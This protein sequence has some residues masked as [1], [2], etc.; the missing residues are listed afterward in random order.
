MALPEAT[1]REAELLRQIDD[2]L[3]QVTR[4]HRTRE[5]TNPKLS[6][7]FNKHS[8]Q[9]KQSV[10]HSKQLEQSAEKLSQ[11]EVDNLTLRDENQALNA[12]S[13]KKRRFR[14]RVRPMPTLKHP[15]PGQGATKG[16]YSKQGDSTKARVLEGSSE[17]RDPTMDLGAATCEKLPACWSAPPDRNRCRR[18][19]F[20]GSQCSTRFSGHS[21]MSSHLADTLTCWINKSRTPC[22]LTFDEHPSVG[23][24]TSTSV[25]EME[26]EPLTSEAALSSLGGGMADTGSL[27]MFPRKGDVGNKK[28]E[29]YKEKTEKGRLTP[30]A[31]MTIRA[32]ENKKST[33]YHQPNYCQPPDL[34]L[35]VKPSGL[36]FGNN[37]G[38]RLRRLQD[39]IKSPELLHLRQDIR[40]SR[41]IAPNPGVLSGNRS[42]PGLFPEFDDEIEQQGA[43]V[44][45]KYSGIEF[46]QTPSRTPAARSPLG[47]TPG[48]HYTVFRIRSQ[49]PPPSSGKRKT[50][51]K[52]SLPYF[53]I[54]KSL[55]YS[56]RLRPALRRLYKGNLNPRARD[57]HFKT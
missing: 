40:S 44:G 43:T 29:S 37:Q 21:F 38:S 19:S 16:H 27:I 2:M 33:L 10:E 48:P 49:G 4:L 55:T 5:E 26:D 56:N 46:L 34:F 14:T 42:S 53:R 8:K 41:K 35:S 23:H 50:S 28:T 47:D 6:P 13:N 20:S 1:Q 3:D 12:A 17:N 57:R 7:E 45:E 30:N 11:L 22:Q 36:I 54:W 31:A 24:T 51:N 32:C 15:I 25:D 39:A 52:K 9:L 18:Y